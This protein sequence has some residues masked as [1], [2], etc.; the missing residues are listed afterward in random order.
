MLLLVAAA[1]Y[2]PTMKLYEYLASGNFILNIGYE[3]GEAG[4]LISNFRAG[5]SVVPDKKEIS[6][7]IKDVVY[8]DLL[9]KWAGPDRRG[10]EELSWPKLAEKLASIL[11]SIAR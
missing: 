4:K 11:N 1:E 9:E 8:G 5:I 2:I 10:I 6:K 7:A 3:W